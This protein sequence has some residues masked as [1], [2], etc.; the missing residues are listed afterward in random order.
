MGMENN[1]CF[2]GIFIFSSS[3]VG[4]ERIPITWQMEIAVKKHGESAKLTQFTLPLFN[5]KPSTALCLLG[6]AE[7]GSTQIESAYSIWG[8]LL[9]LSK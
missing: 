4:F 9:Y 7:R 3:Y 2:F 8:G 5:T 6:S 1:M